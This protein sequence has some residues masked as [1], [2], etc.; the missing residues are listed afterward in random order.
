MPER[1]FHFAVDEFRH[2]QFH[3]AGTV[4]VSGNQA[5]T[6]SVKESPFFPGK[7]PG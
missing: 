7:V 4:L 6:G 5:R 1:A 2:A 3:S